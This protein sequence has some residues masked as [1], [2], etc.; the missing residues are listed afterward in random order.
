MII[1]FNE[2]VDC[3]TCMGSRCPKRRVPHVACDDCG[4]DDTQTDY[5]YAYDGGQFCRLCLLTRL[6]EDEVIEVVVRP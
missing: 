1:Y 2:C 4:T 6:S 5:L 3:E